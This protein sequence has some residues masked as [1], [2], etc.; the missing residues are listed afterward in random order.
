[1]PQL[2]SVVH[3]YALVSVHMV[4]AGFVFVVVV[5]KKTFLFSLFTVNLYY[6]VKGKDGQGVVWWVG[7]C[8]W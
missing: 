7:C 1:M 6:F 8:G 5:T 3:A 2:P 4:H